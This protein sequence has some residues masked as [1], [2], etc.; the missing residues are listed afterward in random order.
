MKIFWAWQS[1][2]PGKTGRHLVREALVEAIAELKQ[3]HELE[4]PSE[5]ESREALHL[6]HDRKGVSGSPDLAR[7]IMEKIRKAAV[8]VGDVTPV[9]KA[10]GRQDDKGKRSVRKKLKKLINSNVAIELGYALGVLG[11]ER[12][13][14]V[15]NKHYG[16]R[17]DLPFDLR[18]KGGPI[19]YELSP[20]ADRTQIDAARQRLR[21]KLVAKLGQCLRKLEF[22]RALISHLHDAEDRA[23]LECANRT[24]Y[25]AHITT[26]DRVKFQSLL[27]ATI[28]EC[29]RHGLT[30]SI[31]AANRCIAE[32]HDDNEWIKI[33]HRI[34][35][36]IEI[37]EDDC[38][39]KR[40]IVKRRS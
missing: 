5:G 12:L 33:Y 1:D 17:A 4:E 38:E 34:R 36:L 14:M 39:R 2:T 11:D 15:L 8:F 21:S 18:H 9:G 3:P 28:R 19:I 16:D 31:D 20:V 40:V 26:P 35:F 29:E 22:S 10:L 6:D 30:A 27:K 24:R 32:F 25:T 7:T 37:I 23:S 13:L